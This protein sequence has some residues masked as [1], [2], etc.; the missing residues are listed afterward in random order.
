MP[1]A[2][3]RD[4][5]AS[6]LIPALVEAGF[7]CQSGRSRLFTPFFRE[8]GEVVHLLEIQWEKNG[9]PRFVL[10][11]G[12]CPKQGLVA[13]S[14]TFKPAE[15]AVG[16]LPD[17]GRL[18]PK[19]GAT[20]ASWFRR[21]YPPLRRLLGAPPLKPAEQVAAEAL[22]LLP[23]VLEYWQ[24]GVPGRHMQSGLSAAERTARPTPTVPAAASNVR[25]K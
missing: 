20:T 12:T 24:T 3:L 16:W 13:G 9:R 21:D 22:A 18:L 15:V 4:A 25:S 23:E 14:R 17:Y 2:A 19:R 1:E 11:Y 8:A 7:R 6:I 10:N 5:V